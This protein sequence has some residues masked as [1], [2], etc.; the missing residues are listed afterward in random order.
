MVM[1]ETVLAFWKYT[2]KDWELGASGL[3]LTLK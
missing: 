3:Q 2:L 1:Q